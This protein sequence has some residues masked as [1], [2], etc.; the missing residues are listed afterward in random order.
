MTQYKGISVMLIAQEAPNDLAV[1][2]VKVLP[3]YVRVLLVK[4]KIKQQLTF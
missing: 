1:F 4:F 3:V 2:R